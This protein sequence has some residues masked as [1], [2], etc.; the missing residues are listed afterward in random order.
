MPLELL[1]VT[2]S[3]PHPRQSHRRKGSTA[4]EPAGDRASATSKTARTGAHAK[5]GPS[6]WTL[7]QLC[8]A[9]FAMVSR[10]S[11][12]GKPTD[13]GTP[14][15]D[16]KHYAP[17]SWQIAQSFE[18]PLIGGI[19]DNPAYGLVV[20]PPLGKQLESLGMQLFDYSPV[21]WRAASAVC[22]VIVILLIAAIARRVTHSELAGM[23][24]G[25][26]ALCDG[27]LFVTGRSAMLD[28]FQT[29]FVVAATYFLV[30]DAQQMDHRFEKVFTEGR[31]SDHAIGPRMGYRWWRFATGVALAGALSVKWSGLYYIAFAGVAIVV[32][33]Y[34]RRRRFGVTEPLRGTLLLDCV[35][36]FASL[37]IVPVVGYL[38]SWRAWF[39]SETGVYRHAVE[40]GRYDELKDSGLSFV[41]DALQNFIYYHS[42]VLKFHT[43]LTNSNG[44]HHSWESKPWSWLVSSRSLL[45]YSPPEKDGVVHK[46]LLVG[47]PAIWW[48]CV[49]VL[50]WGL[51]CLFIHRDA[52]WAV[53]VV[54]FAA[55]FL[56]WLP[57]LDRQMYLF[58]AVNLAPFVVIALAI[59]CCQLI[60]KARV[61]N[62]RWPLVLVIGY[63]AVVVWNFLFFLPL[64]T[65]MPMSNAEFAARMWLPSW[66]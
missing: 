9:V 41:P 50:L 54:G 31:I 16:E 36:S 19:E 22:S 48:L 10:L 66:R 38:V 58:Y 32:L 44:H 60:R 3:A 40:S 21:G 46:V 39:A 52:R 5:R 30:R 4:E 8:L 25:I 29:L 49:P 47:T 14:V 57:N 28:H 34:F 64:Y 62:T 18:N 24:A 56:P 42:S 13:G 26:F 59:A 53:P 15:F 17:Q 55:G 63:V 6:R 33:D 65:G 51:W 35:P 7:I 27:I 20:H 12:L 45:Y 11:S 43:A 61:E 23:L 37:V 2:V 1:P